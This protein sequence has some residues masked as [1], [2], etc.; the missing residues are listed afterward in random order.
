MHSYPSPFRF[1]IRRRNISDDC[2]PMHVGGR[3]QEKR[4]WRPG[5]RGRAQIDTLPYTNRGSA[6]FSDTLKGLN[7]GDASPAQASSNTRPE[8]GNALRYTVGREIM[9]SFL[10]PGVA[11]FLF[12]SFAL[13]SVLPACSIIL[14]NSS[15]AQL[16]LAFNSSALPFLVAIVQVIALS[17][18]MYDKPKP[19]G[20]TSP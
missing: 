4:G 14:F 19:S 12:H 11:L 9:S 7:K 5:K 15:I 1:T 2:Q 3:S 10:L 13:A 18:T 6:R 20:M 17:P 8:T 16:K